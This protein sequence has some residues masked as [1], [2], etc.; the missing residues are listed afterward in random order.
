MGTGVPGMFFFFCIFSNCLG[1]CAFPGKEKEGGWGARFFY[2]VPG[3][4]TVKDGVLFTVLCG[5]Q[6]HF[7]LCLFCR[8]RVHAV[9]RLF[10]R[11]MCMYVCMY[12]SSLWANV[13]SL[14]LHHFVIR[15]EG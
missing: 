13:A 3:F 4:P 10:H 14:L 7:P 12:A 15:F 1:E 11:C 8:V 2:M 6:L 9:F 5:S